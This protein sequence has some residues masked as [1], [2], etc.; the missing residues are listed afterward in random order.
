MLRHGSDSLNPHVQHDNVLSAS[1]LDVFRCAPPVRLS[2]CSCVL[3]EQTG[4]RFLPAAAE[5]FGAAALQR[6]HLR[7]AP[8]G[9]D[10]H[11]RGRLHHVWRDPRRRAGARRP[12]EH[13][14]G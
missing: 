8:V 3:F 1:E 7:G 12:R 2:R 4:G 6:G 5:R 10:L 9:A 13:A 14:V 11:L